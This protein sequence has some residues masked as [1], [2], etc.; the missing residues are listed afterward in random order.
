VHFFICI[1][2][3]AVIQMV[4]GSVLGIG[5]VKTSTSLLIS[6]RSMFLNVIGMWFVLCALVTIVFV[7]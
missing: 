1:N 2:F 6:Y 5:L 7:I 4:H 3:S